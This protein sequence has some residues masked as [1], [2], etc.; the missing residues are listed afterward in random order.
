MR[1]PTL[2]PLAGGLLVAGATVFLFACKLSVN[3]EGPEGPDGSVVDSGGD[4]GAQDALPDTTSADVIEEEET[5]G[6]CGSGF[7]CGSGCVPPGA[8][9]CA[10]CGAG[11]LVCNAT[12]SCVAD[13]AGCP[14]R[15]VMCCNM[16]APAGACLTIYQL[17]VDFDGGCPAPQTQCPCSG[18]DPSACPG[19][20]QVC[21]QGGCSSCGQ[22]PG[23][24]GLSC[25]GSGQCD[26]E[27][28][29]CH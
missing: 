19:S 14:G 29:A 3:G 22:N 17:E 5:D 11:H 15:P 9:P 27:A 4:L 12:Q 18:D 24:N 16:G 21:E 2:L 26:S 28:G 23:T 25:H 6:N 8:S 10:S 7:V 13:C 1:P 20:Q